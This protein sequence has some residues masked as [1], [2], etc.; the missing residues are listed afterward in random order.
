[1]KIVF[2]NAIYW[3]AEL[4]TT[5][6]IARVIFSW[7]QPNPYGLLG[8]IHAFCIRL[9]EP[10]VAPCRQFLSRFNTGMLD[11]SVMMAFLLVQMA[12]N[13]LIRIIL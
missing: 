7:I 3:F 2:V 9:T 12:A 10:I 8:K 5:L 1:M 13:I 6:M 4:L 11:F